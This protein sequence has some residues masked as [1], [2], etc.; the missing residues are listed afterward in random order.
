MAIESIEDTAYPNKEVS[1]LV[2]EPV[3][4][5][6]SLVAECSPS[7]CVLRSLAQSPAYKTENKT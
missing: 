2:L 4:T 3:K 6:L 7:M 5:G 1:C